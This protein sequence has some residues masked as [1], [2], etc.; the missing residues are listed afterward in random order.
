MSAV[1]NGT[2]RELCGSPARS[3]L[4]LLRAD[5][6]LTGAKP[7]GRFG[8]KHGEEAIEAARLARAAGRP[9]KIHWSRAEEFSWGHLRPMAVIDVRAG[10]D[11]SGAIT[12]W[13][14]LDIN[15]GAQGTAFPYTT[16][17]WRLR[18]QPAAS[19][20]AQGPYRALAATANTFAR[21]SC[22]DELAQAAGT[23]PLRFRLDQLG[24]RRLAVVLQA[25][26]ARFG[27]APGQRPRAPAGWGAAAGL[28]KGGRVA[29]CAEV[30]A[31]PAGRLRVTRIVTAYEC[32][33]VVNPDTVTGQI[34][35]GT[36]MALGGALFE[37]V[38]LDHGRMASPSLASYRVPR[39]S[40]VP[41]IEVVLVSR[42][43]I[44]PAGAGETPL[45]AVAPAV[46][47][48]IFAAS[49]RR[50]RSLP[51]IPGGCLPGEG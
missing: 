10:L 12:A 16:A 22:I 23:E 30:R 24:D 6:G 17:N 21:E 32:G 34:E 29:T 25:A 19:P 37:R 14:F 40:D 2:A 1:I 33:A 20:L 8:G 11:A 35:G 4:A 31:G 41:A 51:L 50:L 9:V 43:D 28:E 48:A 15:A 45:I 13:D 44:P 39:F 27:W 46:A 49:G 47:N 26:A 36:I 38:M 3:L 7:G 5:L 18:Y 42:P